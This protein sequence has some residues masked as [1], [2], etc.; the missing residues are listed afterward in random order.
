MTDKN[1]ETAAVFKAFCNENRLEVLNLLCE[2][3]KCACVLRRAIDISQ[4]NLSHHMK[5]LVDSGIV[6]ARQE[7]KWTHYR[8]SLK[9]LVHA[10]S[11]LAGYADA[12]VPNAAMGPSHNAA[13]ESGAQTCA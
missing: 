5:I 12:A 6:I 10:Q 11:L 13:A 1:L 8:L 7:G 4:P 3:E 2:G 9:G